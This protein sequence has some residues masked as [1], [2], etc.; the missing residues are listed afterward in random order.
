MSLTQPDYDALVNYDRFTGHLVPQARLTGDLDG[1][2]IERDAQ[3]GH[4]PAPA[5]Q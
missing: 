4:G 2:A 1:A 3:R 5:G